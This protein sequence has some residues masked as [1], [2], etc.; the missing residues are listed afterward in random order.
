[1]AEPGVEGSGAT[2][3][4]RF[5]PHGRGSL[6]RDVDW[7]TRQI[8]E[9]GILFEDRDLHMLDLRGGSEIGWLHICRPRGEASGG[10]VCW[11]HKL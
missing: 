10:Y 8:S 5:V 2:P 1:M 4:A 3:P 9:C 7:S 6:V 11:P